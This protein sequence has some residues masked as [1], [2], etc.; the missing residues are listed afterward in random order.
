M[1]R[2]AVLAAVLAIALAPAAGAE[3]LRLVAPAEGEVVPLLNETQ[4]A[5]VSMPRAERV[6]AYV[7]DLGFTPGE[8]GAFREIMLEPAQ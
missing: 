6:E 3:P 5:F 8:I 4:K 7:L 1:Q 2:L